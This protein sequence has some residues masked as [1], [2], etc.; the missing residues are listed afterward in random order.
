MLAF[1]RGKEERIKIKH[2]IFG[3]AKDMSQLRFRKEWVYL[4]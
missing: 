2:T 1:G 3:K 4:I